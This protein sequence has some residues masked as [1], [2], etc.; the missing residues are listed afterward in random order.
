MS[1]FATAG[2]AGLL[3]AVAA[4]GTG[5]DGG[6][7]ASSATSSAPSEAAPG[8][9]TP[10]PTP[11]PV[12][13]TSAP[14][15]SAEEQA[16]LDRAL[17]DAAWANDVPRAR[18][19]IAGGADVNAQDETRQS[20][21]LIA[22]SEGYLELLELTLAHGADLAALDRFHGTGLIRAAERGHAAVVGRLLR[23]GIAVDHVNNPGFTALHEAVIYGDGSERY[24]DTV[25]LL[26][27]AGTDVRLAPV[28]DGIPPIEH[29]RSRG[30]EAVVATLRAALETGPVPDPGALL[31]E[32]AAAGDADR[33]A[34]ALRAGAGLETRDA[35]QRTPLLLAATHDR[36]AVARLLVALG[37]D[38][39]ALDDRHDTP[40][41]VTGVTGSVPMLEVLLPAGP[42]L[43]I[44][45]RF[46][47]VSVIPAAERG[48]VDYVRRVVQ[49]G[50]DVNHV[51]DPGWTALL[52]AVVYGDGGPRYQEI[53]RILLAAG[54]DPS[55]ADAEG[56][57]ALEHARARG[58][59][60][61]ARILEGG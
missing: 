42:N 20:A 41:L 21:Y 10:Q 24:V 36:V 51:N 59:S 12:G 58:Q 26:V 33:V 37:A 30:Q 7:A 61:I 46:G 22:T 32:A 6:A 8:T 4:C 44:R 56:I 19:L 47:G 45:N 35:R 17:I 28:R 55:I 9:T 54:A 40:W 5:G 57:T 31:L 13:E 15:R 16:A 34:V 50:I 43:T 3:L 29:A 25:R 49:T 1:R 39:D 27:A 11:T 48:H 2:L 23:A 53:V 60:E 14:P 18:E 38:P 52:E